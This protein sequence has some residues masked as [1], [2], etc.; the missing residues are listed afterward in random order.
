MSENFYT[1][2]GKIICQIC[3]KSFHFITP[4]HLSLHG[5]ITLDEYKEKYSAPIFRKD[6]YTEG[7][8]RGRK[9]STTKEHTVEIILNKPIV[10]ELIEFQDN[11][12]IKNLSVNK[13]KKIK[14]HLDPMEDKNDIIDFLKTIYKTIE[15]NTYITK[16]D[17]NGS[18][19]YS[20]ITDIID[21]KS[22][23]IFN[24]PFSFWHNMETGISPHVKKRML[25]S[26]GW[27][28]IE[29]TTSMP[30]LH[31]VKEKLSNIK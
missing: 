2:D 19:I 7:A 5:D 11:D 31:N 23:T 10:E 15:T 4:R 17:K 14:N 22:K 18:I 21:R 25:E 27:N 24:F 30:R 6:F 16:Y 28:I 13:V 9:S 29:I 26:D 3:K 1:E 12:I 8:K 20:Y